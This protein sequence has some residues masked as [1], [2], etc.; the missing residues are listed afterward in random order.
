MVIFYRKP[1]RGNLRVIRETK[2]ANYVYI[3][4]AAIP[5][6]RAFWPDNAA[7]IDYKMSCSLVRR[8]IVWRVALLVSALVMPTMFALATSNYEY[9]P[10]EYVTVA[11]G[12][13][14]D[15]RYAITAHGGGKLGYDNF[16]LYFTDAMTGKN[17]GPL[18]EIVETLI[19][20][21]MHFPRSGRAIPSR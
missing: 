18:E 4:L 9:R 3:M 10:D 8:M 7:E 17:I 21:P 16:H 2:S 6:N 5:F 13:S 14:P 20:P 15:E 1:R 11:D 12:I 19:P